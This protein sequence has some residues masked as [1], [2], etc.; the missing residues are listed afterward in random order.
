[1]QKQSLMSAIYLVH[2]VCYLCILNVLSILWSPQGKTYSMTK[3]MLFCVLW[4]S[5]CISVLLYVEHCVAITMC[6]PVG[7][8]YSKTVSPWW[9]QNAK[10][11]S[12][13]AYLACHL[14]VLL[15][16]WVECTPSG[17]LS[18]H[19]HSAACVCMFGL[20]VCNSIIIIIIIILIILRCVRDGW[21]TCCSP[22][23]LVHYSVL[24][25]ILW[26][27]TVILNQC[28]FIAVN[29]AAK[30]KKKKCLYHT[31]TVLRSLHC[32]RKTYQSSIAHF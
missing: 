16:I 29:S 14:A 20:H 32:R 31:F 13:Y 27:F 18:E 8:L 21:G 19:G 9:A 2:W 6:S 22:Q 7:F 17:K 10:T 25:I 3:N 30:K 12:L 28:Y 23:E 11:C 26:S 15:M 1:M 24:Q 4:T 5:V